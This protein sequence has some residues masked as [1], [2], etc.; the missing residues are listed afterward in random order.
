[1]TRLP[2]P[3]ER[4]TCSRCGARRVR[5]AGLKRRAKGTGLCRDCYEVQE[6]Q[7]PACLKTFALNYRS[8]H[9]MTCS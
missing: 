1:M 7:C 8:L 6:W 4:Y 2:A 5:N 9:R 3:S